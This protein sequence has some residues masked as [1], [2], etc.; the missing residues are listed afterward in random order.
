[1]LSSEGRTKTTQ[2]VTNTA[3]QLQ[4]AMVN[5]RRRGCDAVVLLLSPVRR[6]LGPSRTSTES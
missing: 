5:P 1:M 4:L 6:L 2:T 3:V